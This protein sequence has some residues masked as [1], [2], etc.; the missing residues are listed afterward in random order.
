[1]LESHEHDEL[2]EEYRG[3]LANQSFSRLIDFIEDDILTHSELVTK[4]NLAAQDYEGYDFTEDIN[5][6]L[7]E[8]I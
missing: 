2:K 8:S 6:L 7:R 3:E 1:M 4:I 5:D